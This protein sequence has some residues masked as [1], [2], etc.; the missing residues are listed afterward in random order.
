V[1]N[2]DSTSLILS[3]PLNYKAPEVSISNADVADKH[4][5]SQDTNSHRVSEDST[6]RTMII[7]KADS[8]NAG[9]VYIG[10]NNAPEFD[11]VAGAAFTVYDSRLSAFDYQCTNAGDGFKYIAGG[12]KD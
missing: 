9:T 1:A 3:K 5:V 6:K 2:E 8:T 4:V 12:S 10:K 7:F 11:L